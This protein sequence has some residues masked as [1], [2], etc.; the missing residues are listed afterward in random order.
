VKCVLYCRSVGRSF[1]HCSLSIHCN[2][3]AAFSLHTV[4]I[5]F[6]SNV[7]CQLSKNLHAGIMYLIQSVNTNMNIRA[8]ELKIQSIFSQKIRS[9]NTYS[10]LTHLTFSGFK[11]VLSNFGSC[12]T[13]AG[14]KCSPSLK[15][16]YHHS[17]QHCNHTAINLPS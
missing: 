10:F 9:H 6:T 5:S 1:T 16:G 8:S 7:L 14:R 12:C 11:Q 3:S 17:A 4:D 15:Q 2:L 13:V